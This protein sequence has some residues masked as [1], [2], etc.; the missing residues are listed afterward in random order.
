M[1]VEVGSKPVSICSSANDR[2]KNLHYTD[3]ADKLT[4][5]GDF[6]EDVTAGSVNLAAH[7]GIGW[8]PIPVNV[9]V[10]ITYMPGFK[11]GAFE[12]NVLNKTKSEVGGSAM[13]LVDLY[14]T[15]KG[16]DGNGDELLREIGCASYS[17]H[18]GGL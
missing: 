3:T 5:T 18:S 15:V 1:G 6:S 9:N 4:V 8:I 7:I 11:K 13:S 16:N 2:I 12:V 17:W 14:G 10:P